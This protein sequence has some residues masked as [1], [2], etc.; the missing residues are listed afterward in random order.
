M[1]T[2]ICRDKRQ[3][4]DCPAGKVDENRGM[5]PALADR[6]YVHREGPAAGP[7]WSLRLAHATWRDRHHLLHASVARATHVHDVY[8]LVVVVSG[9]GSFLGPAGPVAV[10]APW[11]FLVSPGAPHSFQGAPGDDTVYSECTFTGSDRR[12]APLRLPWPRLLAER[13]AQPCPVPAFAPALAEGLDALI[14]DLVACGHGGDGAAEGLV[15]GLLDQALFTVFRRLVAEPG[16]GIDPVAQARRILDGRL[17]DPPSLAELAAAVGLS[18]KHLGRAFA[19]RHGLPPGR[20][21]Q[22]ALMQRA[23]SLLRGSGASVAEVAASL[24]FADPRY[25]IRVFGQVHGRPP[26]VFRRQRRDL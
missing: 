2:T 5:D 12:N 22:H 17:E 14:A 21:R 6:M 24:G 19:R 26:G 15:A 1:S 18:A 13:F 11:L 25:F 9:S 23:A 3:I 4:V 8:H 16:E 7:G 10:R 20:Y